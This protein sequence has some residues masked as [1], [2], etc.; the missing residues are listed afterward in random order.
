LRQILQE[1]GG[2]QGGAGQWIFGN[3]PAH[4]TETIP[5]DRQSAK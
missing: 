3:P 5:F 4:S 1:F 2:Q